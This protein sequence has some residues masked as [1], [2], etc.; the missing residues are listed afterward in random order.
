MIK[1][2][3]NENEDEVILEHDEEADVEFEDDGSTDKDKIKKLKEELKESQKKA[4][5]NMDGWQRALADYANLQKNTNDHI[6]NLKEYLVSGFVGELL[7]VLESFENA[8]SNKEA[9]EKVDKN[10][11]VGVEYIYNQLQSAVKNFG[12][13][14]IIELG[15]N[16]NPEIH[17]AV[18]FIETEEE[19][20]DHK[21]MSIIQKGYKQGG[22]I[23]RPAKVKIYKFKK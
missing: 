7:P 21:V 4:S 8:F 20:S 6:K 16:F 2:D 19:S 3:N 12:V 14:E 17:E 18:D 13:E 9:W 11:R 1:S 23:I 5:E 10:W 22:Q 15:V